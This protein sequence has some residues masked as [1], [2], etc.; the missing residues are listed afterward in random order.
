MDANS[1]C[2]VL[3]VEGER[4]AQASCRVFQDAKPQVQE[5]RDVFE[6][7]IFENYCISLSV[8]YMYN[9]VCFDG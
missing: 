4:R 3:Q 6:Q 5:R 8:R 1:W 2:G 7:L 9:L